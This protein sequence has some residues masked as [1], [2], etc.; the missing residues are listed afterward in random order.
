MS[1]SSIKYEYCLGSVHSSYPDFIMKDS[2]GRIHIFE[3]KSV[4]PAKNISTSFDNDD[5]RAKLEELKRCYKQASLLTEHIFY[6]PV[7]QGDIW[8]I[9]C[10]MNGNESTLSQEQFEKFVSSKPV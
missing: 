9:T 6:L 5:Y 2:F 8:H 10:L 4:N 3:V 1:N 7:L